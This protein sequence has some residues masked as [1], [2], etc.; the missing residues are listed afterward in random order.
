ME[1]TPKLGAG[2]RPEDLVTG[3][4]LQAL[5][6]A[7]VI[8]RPILDF[9][10]SLGRAG[11]RRAI[12]FPGGHRT[13]EPAPGAIEALRG[14]R[15]IF[16]YTHLLESFV[17]RIL[18]RLDHRFVLISHNSDDGVDARF[19][20][21]LGDPRVAAWFAQNAM[22]D[23]P[24]LTHLPIGIA[25]AQWRHGDLGRL[26]AAASVPRGARKG[27]AYCNFSAGTH[28]IRSVVRERMS[29]SGFAW[30]APVRPFGE[31]LSDM[32]GCRWCVSPPGNGEDCHRTWE[33]LYLGVVPIVFRTAW[34]AALFSDLP[35]I[36]I[37]GPDALTRASIEAAQALLDAR[38]VDLRRL[39][40]GYWRERIAEA[41][42]GLSP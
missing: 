35:V 21:A 16:V 26:A 33:A 10:R 3:E 11:V 2:W 17:E 31:Y 7:T 39:A 5:A 25:N 34:N 22:V 4:R 12:L 32:A 29:A 37:D 28:P 30:M 19:L 8:T 18:P 40:M 41:A 1:E 20:P 24:K 14:C 9:H 42:S 27:V 38:G 6:E 36:R 15:T 23:H 13:L